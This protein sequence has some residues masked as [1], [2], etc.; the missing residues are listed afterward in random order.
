MKVKYYAIQDINWGDIKTGFVDTCKV[1]LEKRMLEYLQEI[2]IDSED[3]FNISEWKE[4]TNREILEWYGYE[5]IEI[6]KETYYD[7]E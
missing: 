2:T 1:S 5:V 7:Y 4:T 6:D 3:R